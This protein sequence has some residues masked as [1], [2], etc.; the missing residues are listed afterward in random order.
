LPVPVGPPPL[1]MLAEQLA[2]TYGWDLDEA[3]QA[4]SLSLREGISPQEAVSE[5][6]RQFRK[7]AAQLLTLAVT[8]GER[9]FIPALKARRY[10]REAMIALLRLFREYLLETIEAENPDRRRSPY[11]DFNKI[12]ESWSRPIDSGRLAD[13]V[14]LSV[15]YEEALLGYV[16]P[17]QTLAT[18]LSQ[19]SQYARV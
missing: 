8:E 10:E 3:R 7:E 18:F 11:A 17:M 6:A 2:G 16:N 5:E 15:D 12:R 13:L 9:A 1:E 14:G 19:V 4:A